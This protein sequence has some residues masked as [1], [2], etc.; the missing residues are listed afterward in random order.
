MYKI[1]PLQILRR[2]KG[3]KFDKMIPSDIPKI[4]GIDRIIHGAN[5]ISPGSIENTAIQKK[6]PLYTHSS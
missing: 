6:R 4:S 5:S 2:T 3:V 1:I